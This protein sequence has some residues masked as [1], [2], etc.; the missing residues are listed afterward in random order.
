MRRE[1]AAAEILVA[2]AGARIGVAAAFA[3]LQLGLLHHIVLGAGVDPTI[4]GVV[5]AVLTYVCAVAAMRAGVQ[6]RRRASSMLVSAS[7]LLD[8]ALIFAL[9][10]ITTTPQHYERALFGTIVVV[11]VANFFYGRA[12]AWRVVQVGIIGYLL[13]IASAAA[14]GLPI[15]VAEE[16]WT[17]AIS[18][19]G[20]ALIVVQAS[21]VRRRLRNI[22]SL[23]EMAEVGDFSREYDAQADGRPDAITRVGIAYNGVRAQLAN[24]VLTD[25][26]TRCL[27]R[28]GFDHALTRALGRAARTGSEF[29]LLAID[30]D[31]FKHVN[32]SYGHPAGDVVLRAVGNLLTT[33]A[34]IGDVVA[35]VGG[36]EFSVLL[37][38]T[39]TEGAQLFATRLCERIASY[40]FDIGTDQQPVHLTTSIGVAASSTPG[41]SDFGELLWSRADDALYEA[42]RTGRNCVRTWT[43]LTRRSGDYA[44]VQDIDRASA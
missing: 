35:R 28:R 31:H 29:A 7:L 37:A 42:K 20:A 10:A 18:A 1:T 44:V 14:R 11:N 40:P 9:T 41:A 19:A 16:V 15:E 32:D 30:L 8:L 17:L 36:E 2:H 26:L 3:L 25:P 34:R 4:V 22:V 39:G 12:A 13:L 43:R 24:M 38:D 27:N 33:S 21:D 6:R 5:V 23:F